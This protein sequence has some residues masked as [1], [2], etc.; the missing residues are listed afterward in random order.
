MPWRRSFAGYL[1]DLDG[2]LIDTAPDLHAALNHTLTGSGL[3]PVD[4]AMTR[5]WVGHGAR[6]MLQQ[7]IL[8]QQAEVD[9]EPL[10]AEF[11]DYYGQHLTDFSQPYTEVVETLQAL[12]QAGAKLA[13]VTN[14]PFA[15][16]DRLLQ[17]LGL[18]GLFAALVGGDTCEQ[19]KPHA[20]PVHHCLQQLGLDTQQVLF[21]GDSQTDVLAAQN[22][23]VTVVCLRDGYN[24]GMD[25]E[26]LGADGVINTF[27][28]LRY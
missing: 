13:V 8:H 4:E 2:T 27:E 23:G 19:P 17:Q 12:H 10:M 24:H 11:L 18:R 28:E 1:F 9:V 16:S 26:S 3:A 14:K 5:H 20:Q 7:A 6:A 15:L 22:A 25:V 21:V